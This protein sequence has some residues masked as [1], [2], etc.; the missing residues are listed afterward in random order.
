[1]CGIAAVL[2]RPQE[3]TYNQWEFVK[4]HFTQCLVFNEDRGKSAA[5]LAV[6]QADGRV[7]IAKAPIPASQFVETKAYQSLIDTVGPKTVLLLG[8]ARDPTKGPRENPHNNHPIRTAHTVGVHNGVIRNDDALFDEFGW[9]RTGEVDSEAIFRLL[10]GA[11]PDLPNAAY[12]DAVRARI[13][14]LEGNFATISIDLRNPGRAVVLKYNRP[15]CI[16]ADRDD[17]VFYFS[18]RYIFLRKA[19]G[20]SVITE[21]LD[22]DSIYLFDAQNPAD[23]ELFSLLM[24]EAKARA[25]AD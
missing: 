7:G 22:S 3:R 15:L 16:H 21:A 14:R 4:Y 19:F 18:S 5:G 9:P 1:M 23:P 10:D 6:V 20:R 25:A 12:A 13:N 8:H 2:F 17:N 11:R 24:E